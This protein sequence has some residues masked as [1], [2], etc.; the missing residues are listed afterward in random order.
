MSEAT[1]GGRD[2]PR[3]GASKSENIPSEAIDNGKPQEP[4][5]KTRQSR[6]K[7]DAENEFAEVNRIEKNAVS[8]RARKTQQIETMEDATK[9]QEIETIVDT[10][11]ETVAGCFN[12]IDSYIDVQRECENLLKLYQI[13]AETTLKDFY[14]CMNRVLVQYKTTPQIQLYI[15]LIS[16]FIKAQ[17]IDFQNDIMLRFVDRLKV[18][19]KAVRYRCANL[20]RIWLKNQSSIREDIHKKLLKYLDE[21]SWDKNIFVRQETCFCFEFFQGVEEEEGLRVLNRLCAMANEDPSPTIRKACLRVLL[22]PN[23][24]SLQTIVRRVRDES[25]EVRQTVFK[26]MIERIKLDWFRTDQ[27]VEI[28]DQGLADPSPIVRDKCEKVLLKWFLEEKEKDI[29]LFLESF[30]VELNED[31][32]LRILKVIAS[33]IPNVDSEITFN[34]SKEA[35]IWLRFSCEAHLQEVSVSDLLENFTQIIQAMKYPENS[36][37]KCTFIAKQLVL[38]VSSLNNTQ[39]SSSGDLIIDRNLTVRVLS[40][41]LL[42]EDFPTSL[43]YPICLAYRNSFPE[44]NQFVLSV[45]TDVLSCL[46]EPSPIEQ[47]LLNIK[48]VE[49]MIEENTRL[50]RYSELA[51][52]SEEFENLKCKEQEIGDLNGND[53]LFKLSFSRLARCASLA[54]AILQVIDRHIQHPVLSSVLDEICLPALQSSEVEERAYGIQL[55]GLLSL[56]SLEVAKTHIVV[57][58]AYLENVNEDVQIRC[59]AL[60]VLF[61]LVIAFG[62]QI[63]NEIADFEVFIRFLMTWLEIQHPTEIRVVA[64]HGLAKL[65]FLGRVSYPGLVQCLMIVFF[66]PSTSEEENFQL[67]QCLTTFF[68]EYKQSDIILRAAEPLIDAVLSP[69]AGSMCEELS[70]NK[71]LEHL[72]FLFRP[73]SNIEVDQDSVQLEFAEVLMTKLV[74]EDILSDSP[75][76]KALISALVSIQFPEK[77][78]KDKLKRLC[79]FVR[80]LS[81]CIH[82]K[83][84]VTKLEKFGLYLEKEDDFLR[85][86][87]EEVKLE[88]QSRFKKKIDLKFNKSDKSNLRGK[89]KLQDNESE[90]D[91]ETAEEDE[92]E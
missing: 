39:D 38:A 26:E 44:V 77:V 30:H 17:N 70:L 81:T 21:T 43:I 5:K 65:L 86:L 73:M 67:K 33:K 27:L 80:C 84:L 35:A 51:K 31:L 40:E 29:S 2:R 83:L 42:L 11:S 82:E 60:Q 10:V 34:I 23:E 72:C 1:L 45:V 13:D 41:V 53:G 12:N 91:F 28:F 16:A 15:D 52:L 4:A 54:C 79:Y 46:S 68:A 20:L 69:T 90:D 9:E 75:K 88:V 8:T 61:D 18:K 22:L 19:D 57:V 74:D 62:Q 63:V 24:V 55:L 32:A 48:R 78:P 89:K 36:I 3:R 49:Q 76:V 14:V 87:S 85:D 92:E 6:K 71:V 50:K 59:K 47:I 25:D 56:R 58:R 37:E 7:L 64:T 66:H